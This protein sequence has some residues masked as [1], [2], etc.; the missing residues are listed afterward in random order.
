M[1]GIDT[2]AQEPEFDLRFTV[3]DDQPPDITDL[4]Q[5]KPGGLPLK[6]RTSDLQLIHAA[7]CE[8]RSS[9]R[10]SCGVR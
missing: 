8:F 9:S 5:P 1:L 2:K 7:A 10:T 6:F 4:G 3:A